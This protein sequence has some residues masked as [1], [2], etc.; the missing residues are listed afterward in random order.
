MVREHSKGSI[1][2]LAV[3]GGTPLF[4]TPKPTS[5]LV[6]PEPERF[7]QYLSDRSWPSDASLVEALET[8]L[9]EMHGVAHCVVTNS[10]FWGFAMLMD[11]LLLPDKREVIMPSLTYRRMADIVA[12]VGRVPHFCDIDPTTLANSARTVE[13]CITTETALIIG[14]HPVGGHC[15]IDGLTSLARGQGIPLLF[16]SVEAVHQRHAD[17]RIGSFGNAELFSLGASKL[18]NGFEGGYVTTNDPRLAETLRRKREGRGPGLSLTAPLPRIHAAMALAGLDD[19]PAQLLRNRMRFEC[20]R[21]ALVDLPELRL[22]EQD[23]ATEPS[24]KNIVIEVTDAW[25]LTRDQ[26]IR[27][28]N[29]ER[30][31][32]R[33]YYAPPLTHKP[34]GYA[35][36]A[37]DLPWTDWAAAR[38]IS[39][40]CGHLVTNEDIVRIVEM[41]RHLK[42]QAPAIH[43][44]LASL[45]HTG[46]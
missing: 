10:G 24:Y 25:P 17:Q 8:R 6:R 22:I 13:A 45:Q 28:L 37:G 11:A 18:V 34:I 3:F 21:D 43:A 7:F 30:I 40:P 42:H 35:H 20:Y 4:G 39:L 29:A 38:F 14:V 15:D 33:P 26:T 23:L 19:L 31:L 2:D 9:A 36:V 12:W 44:G 16:D 1:R 32:A 27:V 5:N 46:G 41:L